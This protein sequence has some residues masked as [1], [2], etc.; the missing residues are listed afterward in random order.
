MVEYG[1]TPAEAIRAATV[2][3]SQLLHL[4]DEIGT[5]ETG[6]RA[7]LVAVPSDPLSDITALE[8]VDFVM[9]DGVVYKSAKNPE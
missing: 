3:G 9:K 8:H 4:Q 1:M 7:D 5:V 2:T 6:K